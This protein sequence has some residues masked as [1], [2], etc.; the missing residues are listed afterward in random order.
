[1]V[2][3]K[4]KKPASTIAIFPWGNVIE[5]F[6]Q[7]ID[8]TL[9]KF[10][11][12]MTGGWLFGYVEA[13]KKVGISS[14]LICVSANL[15]QPV[16]RIHVPTGA[17]IW[18]LPAPKSYLSIH[19]NMINP[20]GHNVNATF[21]EVHKLNYFGLSILREIAPYLSTPLREIAKV[22]KDEDCQAIL[23]QE[24]EYA[25]FDT[26]VL[27]G[28]FLRLPVYASFQGGDFQLTKLEN[29]WRRWLIHACDGLIVA[30]H[31]EISRLQRQYDL[32]QTKT[33]QIFN[34]LD[35]SLWQE[36]QIGVAER[37]AQV[38]SQLNLPLDAVV[39]VYH[40]RMELHRKGLD[41]L[42][43]AWA[44]LSNQYPNQNWWLLLVG[45][46]SDAAELSDRIAALPKQTVCWVNEY[47]LDRRLLQQ[48]LSASDLYVLP[49]RHEGFPV[50][51]LEAMACGLPVVATEVP[52]IP[53]ILKDHENSGGIRVPREDPT[54]LALALERL[55]NDADLRHR[56]G[57]NARQRVEHH[58][59]LVSVGQQLKNLMF[60]HC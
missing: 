4:H 13:L 17:I 20:Y 1:M 32:P 50:A 7:S 2:S 31:S 23:C 26:C 25:R 58:F 28:K 57:E 18:L 10:C 42:L 34:P 49:S 35:F 24:Y 11:D 46:G 52:G 6:L 12:E 29:L 60:P 55:L 44:Q 8:L 3:P 39:V 41:I 43:E 9:D 56:L 59:S 21:G 51:P 53:D 15:V 19:Q 45:T 16:R 38:R 37:C 40:G 54:Q 36:N 33:T 27:L 48:Y 14:V 47:I 22:L 30:T 5:D